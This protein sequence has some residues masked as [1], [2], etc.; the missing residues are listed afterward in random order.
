MDV[1]R[2]HFRP[3]FI[4]RIDEIIVFHALD[5]GAD[6]RHRRAAARA[7]EAHRARPG[8]RRSRSTTS[9]VEHL[10]AAGFRP[11]FG[12]RELR[13]LIRSELETQLARAMLASEVKEGDK[14]RARWDAAAGRVALEP[15]PT[16]AGEARPGQGETP[17]EAAN[18][19]GD[20]PTARRKP[21]A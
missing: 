3:E 6:P 4:N 13:R 5:R 18:Q 2:G 16:A 14:V 19:P 10:A 20:R 17:P 1:L 11:E 21:A 9:L 7:G 8:R 12:A 15:R